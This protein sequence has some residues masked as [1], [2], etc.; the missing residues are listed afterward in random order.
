[1]P[2][3]DLPLLIDAAKAA[4]KI[5]LHY[6]RSDQTVV[7][8]PDGAGP[9]SEGDL[10]VDAA[11]KE[12]LMRARP[13]YG[14][15]SEET[16]DTPERL[17]QE[18]VFIVDPIDGTRSYVDGQET[19]AHSLA[20]VENGQPTAA[21]VYLPARDKLYAAALGQG[22]TLNGEAIS[23]GTRAD[24]DGATILVPKGNL[25]PQ[26][27]RGSVPAF[28]RHFRPSLAYRLCLIADGRF[29]V[30]LTLRDAW[31]WDIAGGAL[32]AAEAGAQITDRLGAPLLFNSKRA[33][34]TGVLTTNAALHAE[35]LGRL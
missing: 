12:Q 21:V 22:A 25:E 27:W 35:V 26:H 9:V 3:H 7:D 18:R 8:K 6:W 13:D 31:E 33:K 20:V 2:A 34:T 28:D 1:L 16:E 10:A 17:S 30:M 14:W 23:C 24:A 11:L 19:W 5:A 15:L 32:I 29:D 4:S